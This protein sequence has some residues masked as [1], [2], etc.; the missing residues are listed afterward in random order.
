MP[1]TAIYPGTF[2]PIT[3]GHFDVI[4][5]ALHLFDKV[6]VA[7]AT[8]ESKE[9]LFDVAKRVAMIQASVAHLDNVT[10]KPFNKLLVD[11][12]KE[13]GSNIIVRGLRNSSDFEYEL[14]LDYVNHSLN[15]EI[16]TVYLMPYLEHTHI[17]SS[18]VRTLLSFDSD[19]KKMIPKEI[20]TMIKEP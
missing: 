5:R 9:P 13:N 10:V 20:L 3:L 14:Q 18:I 16:E 19:V 1:K 11:F 6:V 15:K 8:S 12:V 7:V 17:S 2:D 4:E